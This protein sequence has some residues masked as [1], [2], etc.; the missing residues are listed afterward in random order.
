MIR[1]LIIDDEP[2]AI[3]VLKMHLAQLSEMHVVGSFANPVE[4]LETI[5]NE[6][7]D[8]IFLDIEMPVLS[9]IDFVKNIALA[10]KVIFTTAYRNY[11]IESYELDVVD[12]LLKPI[13]FSRFLKAINKYKTM[14]QLPITANNDP[15]EIPRD[16]HIYVNANKKFIKLEFD[17]ITYVESMKDY[18][19]IH[20][21]N[22]SVVTKEAITS[23]A[24]KLPAEFLRIHRSF[25][26]NTKKVTAFTKVDVEINDRELPIGSS[27]KETV[28]GFLKNE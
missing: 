4:S 18:V 7:I 24:A 2:L 22:K 21:T 8:L 10:P 5:R 26:V 1:C 14:V 20:A 27:Y 6:K 17:D 15:E 3:E 19:Q 23:F 28:M 11:A 9:G 16:N 25:I 12:Y 13:A